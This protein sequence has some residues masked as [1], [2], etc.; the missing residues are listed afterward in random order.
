MIIAR[1]PFPGRE[2][3]LSHLLVLCLKKLRT[4]SD[5]VAKRPSKASMDS[6][7]WEQLYASSGGIGRSKLTIT[8]IE[9]KLG[10]APRAA[11]EHRPQLAAFGQGLGTGR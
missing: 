2:R 7:R 6:R 8:L 5:E 11:T 4:C 10:T 9:K 3:D 1:N